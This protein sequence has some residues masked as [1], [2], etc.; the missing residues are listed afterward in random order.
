MHHIRTMCTNTGNACLY[1]CT[2]EWIPCLYL[3]QTCTAQISCSVH[4]ASRQGGV[5]GGH[6]PPPPHAESAHYFCEIRGN[7]GSFYYKV[8]NFRARYA[9]KREKIPN[10]FQKNSPKGGPMVIFD[11]IYI[12]KNNKGVTLGFAH[13]GVSWRLGPSPG[14]C[15]RMGLCTHMQMFTLFGIKCMFQFTM[16]I[17]IKKK[18]TLPYF[19]L[20]ASLLVSALYNFCII[21]L[22]PPPLR[23]FCFPNESYK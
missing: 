5:K 7:F 22:A 19:P 6:C 8:Q 9:R 18:I 17:I 20:L 23:N 15:L 2:Y 3:I 13:C 11:H 1:V 12:L 21:L 4:Q 16:A 10:F 14:K